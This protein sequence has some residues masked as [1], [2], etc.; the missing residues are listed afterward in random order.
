MDVLVRDNGAGMDEDVHR[1]IFE[2]FFSNKEVGKAWPRLA[3]VDD[4]VSQYS[5][6]IEVDSRRGEGTTVACV[7]RRSRK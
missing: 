1:H 4:I 3:V 6:T 2:P 7:C 5:E